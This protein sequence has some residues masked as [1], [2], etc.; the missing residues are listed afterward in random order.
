MILKSKA[1]EII[2][3]KRKEITTSSF[4][5]LNSL[6]YENFLNNDFLTSF[7]NKTIAGYISINNECDIFKILKYYLDNKNFIC[8]PA[9]VE[10]NKPMVFKDWKCDFNDL[11]IN[12][13]FKKTKIIE[14][15][16]YCGNVVPNIVFIPSV[17]V[18][19]YGNRVGYGS[20][21]YDKVLTKLNS[22]KI[23]VVF[24][25]QVFDDFLENNNNDV[26]VD[27]ILTEKRLLN[28]NKQKPAVQDISLFKIKDNLI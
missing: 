28:L 2:F 5:K 24:E 7:K 27:Y 16:N 9:I 13:L 18:D 15:N 6:L 21:Y 26:K 11:K 14:P 23:A 22:I 20:G 10:K 8:L 25:F 3:K 1:R 4:N 19:I 17:S 12:D